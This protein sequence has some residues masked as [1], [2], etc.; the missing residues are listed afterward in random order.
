MSCEALKTD[1]S[2]LQQL[3][4]MLREP[5]SRQSRVSVLREAHKTGM[6]V[7]QAGSIENGPAC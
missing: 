2:N 5:T 3:P 1:I 4:T 6:Q 7:S